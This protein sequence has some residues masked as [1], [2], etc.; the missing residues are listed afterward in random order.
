MKLHTT[1]VGVLLGQLSSLATVA[2]AAQKKI[3]IP[4]GGYTF[5]LSLFDD[6]RTTPYR[7]FFADEYLTGSSYRLSADGHV[8]YFKA[9]AELYFDRMVQDD[10]SITFS[11]KPSESRKH[12]KGRP[13]PHDDYDFSSSEANFCTECTEA[14]TATCYSGLPEFCTMVDRSILGNDGLQSMRALCHNYKEVCTIVEDS[15]HYL[16]GDMD[17]ELV[18]A[19]TI[20]AIA[21]SATGFDERPGQASGD[22]GCGKYGCLPVLATDG[23]TDDVES[24]WSCAEDIV[25]D[26]GQCEIEFTF[27]HPQNLKQL[28]VDF[29]K[30]E[31]RTR[32]L[33]VKI[34]G[35]K[36]GEFDSHPGSVTSYFDVIAYDV[37][38][39][40]L[41]SLGLDTDEW[42]SLLEVIFMVEP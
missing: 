3:E 5:K 11:K 2:Q 32:T 34:N 6:G 15:C 42:I 13:E 1:T 20:T 40:T 36:F 24:R 10:N 7:V 21:A 31:E 39:V 12:G 41:E 37:H 17:H 25:P 27:S 33:K 8:Q 23:I 35:E 4:A 19:A 22:H 14:I 30:G 29:W 18:N 38:T 26:G 16:C 28:Q 9:G